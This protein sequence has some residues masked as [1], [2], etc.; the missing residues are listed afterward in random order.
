MVAV[1]LSVGRRE[2]SAEDDGELQNEDDLDVNSDMALEG[3]P[4]ALAKADPVVDAD[5]LAVPVSVLFDERLLVAD[6]VAVLVAVPECVAL[7]EERAEGVAVALALFE[8]RAL[9]LPKDDTVGTPV[10]LPEAE[11]VPLAVAEE[12]ALP[13]AVARTVP[14]PAAVADAVALARPVAL[15]VSDRVIVGDAVEEE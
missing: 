8:A 7:E 9:A 3:D 11:T 1:T 5:E 10:P 4:L 15:A 12:V 6:V 13:L 2:V 14:V